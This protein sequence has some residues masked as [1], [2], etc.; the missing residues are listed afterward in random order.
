[1]RGLRRS[2]CGERHVP[3][4]FEDVTTVGHDICRLQSSC[5]R[6]LQLPIAGFGD[7][8]HRGHGEEVGGS[9][10]EFDNQRLVIGCALT[11]MASTSSWGTLSGSS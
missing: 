1:M 11:P 8:P 9:E 4:S 6:I 3:S 2:L 5:R 7:C 10:G